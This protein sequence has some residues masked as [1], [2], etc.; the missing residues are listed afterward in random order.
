[1][2]EPLPQRLKRNTHAGLE[3]PYINAQTRR[4]R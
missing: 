4:L 1:M 3:L 2:K